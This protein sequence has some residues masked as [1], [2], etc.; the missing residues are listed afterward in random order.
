MPTP[1]APPTPDLFFDTI[2][3][4]QRTAALRAA[5]ELELFTVVG[6]GAQTVSAI[7]AG[8]K[9]SEPSTST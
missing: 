6:D 2:Q 8:C 9:A 7:A 5:I 1:T 4:Y 3:A